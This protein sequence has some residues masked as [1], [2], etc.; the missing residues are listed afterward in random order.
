MENIT[1]ICYI[2]LSFGNVVVNWYI[3]STFWYIVSIKNL[4]PLAETVA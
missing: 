3:F 4:A 2:L 1:A